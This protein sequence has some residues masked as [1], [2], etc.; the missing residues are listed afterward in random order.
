MSRL[1]SIGNLLWAKKEI[2]ILILGLVCQSV[3]GTEPVTEKPIG[4]RWQDHLTL[5]IKGRPL[6]RIV[7]TEVTATHIVVRLEKLLQRYQP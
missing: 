2:R 3:C 1:W 5:S 4:Q 6:S 7:F